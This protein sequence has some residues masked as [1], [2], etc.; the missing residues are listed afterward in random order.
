MSVCVFSGTDVLSL[1]VVYP[2]HMTAVTEFRGAGL[3]LVLFWK[4]FCVAHLYDVYGLK[5][6]RCDV[7]AA[8]M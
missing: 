6:P 5:T 2:V 3:C 4:S 8:A 1:D 7:Q